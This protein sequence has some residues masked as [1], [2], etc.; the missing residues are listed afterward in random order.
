M[1]VIEETLMDKSAWG[2]GPWQDEP[3][4]RQWA[5]EATGLP[6]L[7]VRGPIGALCGYVGVPPD[8]PAYGLSYDGTPNKE[9]RAYHTAL[10]EQMRVTF[11]EKNGLENHE[12]VREAI[13]G[14]PERPKPVPGAGERIAEMDIHGGLTYAA[15]CKGHI[16]HVPEKYQPEN[17]W[18]F[19]F[20]CAHAMD[21]C[22]KMAANLK[23][24]KHLMP[25]APPGLAEAM[26]RAGI[27]R[28]VYRNV[29]YVTAEC[30][31][32]AKQLA[33]MAGG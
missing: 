6:C 5:D 23:K 16:C 4:K 27:M 19:G 21:L 28:D 3:D 10:R 31:S 26:E 32:L 25:P 8:H 1:K 13:M 20:D 12:A 7:I 18:W 29:A 22:P 33:G 11:K 17:V 2:P 24:I 30:A 14:L 15:G 9:H